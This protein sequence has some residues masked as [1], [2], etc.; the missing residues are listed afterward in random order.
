MSETYTEAQW[1]REIGWGPL[2]D[3]YRAKP[4]MILS[5]SYP[6]FKMSYMVRKVNYLEI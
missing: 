2:P 5:V 4:V 3:K 1:S 6:S